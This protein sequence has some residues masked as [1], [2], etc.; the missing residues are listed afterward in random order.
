M[1][2]EGWGSQ[3]FRLCLCLESVRQTITSS[4]GGLCSQFHYEAQIADNSWDLHADLP[5]G[6]WL[7][8]CIEPLFPLRKPNPFI[9]FPPI[10]AQ[11]WAQGR[12]GGMRE[13]RGLLSAT[14]A[15]TGTTLNIQQLSTTAPQRSS[16]YRSSQPD[17][18]CLHLALHRSGLSVY[19]VCVRGSEVLMR[20]SERANSN[21]PFMYPS[22]SHGTPPW[23]L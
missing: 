3:I 2:F 7:C 18:L 4:R 17:S 19:S 10:A 15:P 5:H 11:A 16:N 13:L 23:S 6:P 12:R 8:P 21:S 20:N 22:A 1:R 9:Q 14:V